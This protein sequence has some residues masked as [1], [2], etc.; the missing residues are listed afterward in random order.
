MSI[1]K[2]GGSLESADK[3]AKL[4]GLTQYDRTCNARSIYRLAHMP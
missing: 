2:T 4:E 3:W 1:D